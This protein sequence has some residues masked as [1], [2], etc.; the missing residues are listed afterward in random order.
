MLLL[1]I[2]PLFNKYRDDLFLK[3]KIPILIENHDYE[4]VSLARRF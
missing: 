1:L 3:K 2:Y 4:G